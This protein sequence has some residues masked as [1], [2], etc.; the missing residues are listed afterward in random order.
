MN[1]LHLASLSLAIALLQPALGA[2]TYPTDFHFLPPADSGVVNV[3]EYGAKGDGK[4]DDTLAIRRAISENIMKSRYRANPMFFFPD[5]TYLVTG[6]IESRIED[7]KMWEGWR[8]GCVL[9]G[10]SRNGTVIRLADKAEGYGDPKNPKWVVAFGSEGHGG[11]LKNGEG[12]QGFRQSLINMTVDVGAGNPGAIAVDFVANNRGSIDNV[13]IRAAK[14]SGHTGIS[15]MRRWPGPAMVMD[16]RI[17]GFARGISMGHYQYGMTFENIEMTGQRELGIWNWANVL[18][19]RRVRFEGDVPFYKTDQANHPMLCLLDSTITNTGDPSLAAIENGGMLNLRRV[20]FTGYGTI[21][22]NKSAKEEDLLP[23]S[24]E[25]ATVSS[26][27][28]GPQKSGSGGKATPLNLPIEEIP[29]VRPPE[30]AKWTY[31]GSTGEE[32]QAVID[33]GAEYVYLRPV[34]QIRMEKSLVLRGK[35]KLLMGFQGCILEPENGEPTIIVADGESSGRPVGTHHHV[36]AD[37]QPNRAH[38]RLPAR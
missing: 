12:N 22:K 29:V 38:L 21:V 34:Q 26:Y 3:K 20:K 1:R 28:I 31:G 25:P 17:E 6:P 9:I 27:D 2:E 35:L 8:S 4:T 14:D 15:L 19:M 7:T 16:T 37:S 18:Q 30:G 33:S 24:P 23:P 5:G 32:L 10:E 13:T 36:R 11:A